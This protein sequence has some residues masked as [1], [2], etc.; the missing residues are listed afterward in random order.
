MS[1]LL[2]SAGLVLGAL[3]NIGHAAQPSEGNGPVNQVHAAE[4]AALEFQVGD[5]VWAY[6]AYQRSF[7]WLPGVVT[8]IS[9]DYY[10]VR[11]DLGFS[12]NILHRNV[13]SR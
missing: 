2:L 8:H 11:F 6:I 1:K 7:Q 4:R 3:T 5:R 13:K 10:T 9:P 12:S